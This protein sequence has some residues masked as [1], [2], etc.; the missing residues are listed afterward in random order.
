MKKYNILLL[1]GLVMTVSLSACNKASSKNPESGASDAKL[2]EGLL[3]N[4]SSSDSII[5]DEESI[6]NG[7]NV[8]MSVDLDGDGNKEYFVIQRDTPNGISMFGSSNDYG[9]NMTMDFNDEAEGFDSD[10]DLLAGYYMQIL[11]YDL[12]G[13]GVKEVLTSVGDKSLNLQT[14]VHKYVKDSSTLF[15]VVGR[16]QGQ[17]YQYIDPKSKEI[18]APYGSQGLFDSYIYQ[19]GSLIKQENN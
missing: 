13:D 14:V 2:S 15:E 1:L 4:S 12:D 8:D 16:I 18:I 7:E 11:C 17:E 3:I 5:I 10:G 9:Y 19:N 6:Y